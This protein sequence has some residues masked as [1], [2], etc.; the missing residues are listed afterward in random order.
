MLMKP[1]RSASRT[2][3]APNATSGSQAYLSEIFSSFQGEGSRAGERHLFVRFAGCGARCR[4]CDTPESLTRVDSCTVDFPDGRHE[5]L[6]NPMSAGLLDTIV[7]ASCRQDPSI[8][9]VALT[10]G[11]PMLQHRFLAAWLATGGCPVPCLL[12]TS[13]LDSA[14]L[15]DV[16]PYVAVV[17]ADVKLPSNS[18]EGDRWA[19]HCRFFTCVAAS[20]RSDGSPE[21]YVKMPVDE[22]TSFDDVR[23][24]VRMIHEYLPHAPVFLQPITDPAGAWRLTSERLRAL[25]GEAAREHPVVR[26]RPQ[27]HKLAGWR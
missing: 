15:E 13:G 21:V 24:G 3:L 8:G 7:Q 18:G 10:G 9:M 2:P 22:G 20:R 5:R 6:A 12:E 25:F 17:S 11:E 4:Y 1:R 14:G 23:R 26:V 16:L 19:D 27:L